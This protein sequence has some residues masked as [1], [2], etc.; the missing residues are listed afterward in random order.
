PGRVRD[1]GAEVDLAVVE[2]HPEL[3]LGGDGQLD[4]GAWAA[5][6]VVVRGPAA[7]GS[8]SWWVAVPG[9]TGAGVPVT[10]VVVPGAAD[11]PAWVPELYD[12]T[13]PASCGGAAPRD[14]CAPAR[15][16]W[17]PP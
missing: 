11:S 13:R 1:G 5:R 6:G 8:G 4:A 9:V 3:L 12:G 7:A 15:W 10:G 14:G 17:A 2:F 16:P